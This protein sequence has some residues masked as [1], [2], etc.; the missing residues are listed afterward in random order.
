MIFTETKLS[1]LFIVELEKHLDERGFNARLWCKRELE[2]HQLDSEFV[3]QNMIY[4]KIKGTLRGM[5]YQVTPHEEAK[6]VRCQK[7]AISDVVIDLR[8]DSAT[9]KQWYGIELSSKNLK[10]IYVPQGF[11]HGFQS[12]IEDSEIVYFVSAFYTPQVER[13]I[14]YNDPAIGIRWPLEVTS[15]S[16]KDLNWPD[17]EA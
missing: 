7:G 16:D 13:G 14:R 4:T 6:L 1:G 8:S 11:A 2:D 10:M 12:L 17:F 5:H 3:Q 9:Y 15:I